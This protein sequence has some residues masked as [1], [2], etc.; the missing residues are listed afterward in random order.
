MMQAME[1]YTTRQANTEPMDDE[2]MH[3]EDVA[4]EY[5]GCEVLAELREVNHGAH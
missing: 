3:W 4:A 2:P 5:L 1:D